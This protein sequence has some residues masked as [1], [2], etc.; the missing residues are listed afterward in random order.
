MLFQDK[1]TELAG[2]DA[3]LAQLLN[4]ITDRTQFAEEQKVSGVIGA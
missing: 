4:S 1:E 3:E 2:K